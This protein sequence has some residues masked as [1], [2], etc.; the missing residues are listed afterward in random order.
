M[1][2]MDFARRLRDP[3]AILALDMRRPPTP[4]RAS[5]PSIIQQQSMEEKILRGKRGGRGKKRLKA[6]KGCGNGKRDRQG[7]DERVSPQLSN[8]KRTMTT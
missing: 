4:P 6:K 8:L 2:C 5:Y 3:L 1:E 7:R